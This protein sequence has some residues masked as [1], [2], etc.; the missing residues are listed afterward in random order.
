MDEDNDLPLSG[1]SLAHVDNK[2]NNNPTANQL[3]ADLKIAIIGRPN[4]GKSSLINKL[5][6]SNLSI[7][8]DLAG[9]TRDVVEAQLHRN[10][11]QSE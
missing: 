9:T 3:D 11:Y 10:Q 4:V 1:S 5:M 8:H 2:N 7:V 6:N